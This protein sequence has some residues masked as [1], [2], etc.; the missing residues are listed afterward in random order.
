[1]SSLCQVMVKKSWDR[2]LKCSTWR[3][4]CLPKTNP[5]NARMVPAKCFRLP[6]F[7]GVSEKHWFLEFFVRCWNILFWIHVFKFGACFDHKRLVELQEPG[8]ELPPGMAWLLQYQAEEERLWLWKSMGKSP[9]SS[10]GS[11]RNIIITILFDIAITWANKK[12]FSD[13]PL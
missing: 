5:F 3:S 2:I 7:L 6:I 11:S 12:T 9:K 4:P 10:V 13:T 1:M 8:Q